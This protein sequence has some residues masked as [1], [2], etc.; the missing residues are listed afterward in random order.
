[1]SRVSE[2]W[3]AKTEHNNTTAHTDFEKEMQALARL[4]ALVNKTNLASRRLSSLECR[5]FLRKKVS[6]TVR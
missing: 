1:M 6:A 4:L 2:S 3:R 5:V